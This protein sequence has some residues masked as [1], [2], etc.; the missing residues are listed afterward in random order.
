MRGRW[1]G[2]GASAVPA[3]SGEDLGDVTKEGRGVDDSVAQGGGAGGFVNLQASAS[4]TGELDDTRK[5]VASAVLEDL[6]KS[7]LMR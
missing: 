5:G 6:V 4:G 3:S 7:L 1:G 2:E